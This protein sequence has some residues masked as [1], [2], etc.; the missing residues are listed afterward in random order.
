MP[1]FPHTVPGRPPEDQ[2]L[3]LEDTD[4]DGRADKQ[5]VFASGFDALDGI[6]F[7]HEGVIVSEQPRLWIMQDTDGD[8][9]ADTRR[10][11]LRGIDVTD[12]H[13]GGMIATDPAAAVWFC[14]GVFHRSQ[15]ETPFGVHRGID[16]TTYRL[17]PVTGRVRTEWQSITPNPWKITFDRWGNIFQMYGDGLVL[18]GLALT[19]TPMGVYH[20]FAYARTVGYGKGSAAA[21]VSSP[22]FPEEYQQGM[23]SAALLGSHVVSLTQY[24]FDAG[25]VKGSQRLDL[26]SSNNA[27]F[28]PADLAFGMDG[29][30]YVSDF[31]SAI[32]GHAQHPMRDPHWDH[33]HGRIWRVHRKAGPIAKEWPHIEGQPVPELCGLLTHPQDLVR[34]HARIEL[35]KRGRPVLKEVDAWLASLRGTK[36]DFPQAALE[37]LFVCEGLGETRPLLLQEL[38]AGDSAMHRA[39]AVHLLRLQA[40]RISGFEPLVEKALGD[41]HPRVQM[42]AVDLV[43]HLR[44]DFPHLEHLLHAIHPEHATVQ[45]MLADLRHGTR[46]VRG[47]SVPVLD[48]DGRCQLRFWEYLA[49]DSREAPLSHSASHSTS[50]PTSQPTSK[51][52]GDG[53]GVYRTALECKQAQTALL[54]IKHRYLDV[55]VNGTQVFSQDSQWSSEQQI[56]CPL[57]QG[58]NQIEVVLRKVGKGGMPPV[59]LF[60]AVG[61][62]LRNT[63]A[64]DSDEALRGLLA[65]WDALHKSSED[66]LKIQAVPG[67]MQFAPAEVRVSKGAL[68]RLVFENPDLMLHNFVLVAPGAADEVGQL[69]DQLA[70]KPE[71]LSMGYVPHSNKVLIASPLVNPGQKHTL[72]WRAPSQPGR[73]PFLCTFPGHWRTMK[74]ELVVE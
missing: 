37:V 53:D 29:A 28:R 40:D 61:E 56:P 68:V 1:S 3:V 74:G 71:G 70:A 45:Q 72:E 41:A 51:A 44:P 35:R 50:Q 32:I 57:Q 39:A 48:V 27:A 31:C 46:P 67:K 20:P 6:A 9:R 5:T 17:N 14:D 26:M 47:R 73:Y 18:D 59:F 10:E 65:G 62:P 19:W 16:S 42:E 30:L 64:A 22:N 25:L 13:H 49:K 52:G 38:L 21:S 8:G 54:G 60:D 43:A 58:M 24:Q 33:E 2:I 7:H 12:S 36:V 15:L 55:R 63:R 69:S 34:E 11:L 66:G 23:A 4:H